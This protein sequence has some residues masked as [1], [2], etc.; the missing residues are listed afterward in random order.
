MRFLPTLFASAC[1][2]LAA[3][4]ADPPAVKPAYTSMAYVPPPGL[5]FEVTGIARLPDGRV[6]VA[7]RKGEVWL[8]QHPDADPA[9]P[10]AV[11]Y[12][13]IASGLHEALGLLWHNG[14][15]LTMQRSE[16]TRLR[17]LDGD[18]IIDD[19]EC[20]AKGWGVSGNYHEYAYGPVVDHEGNLWF[21]LNATLGGG[22]RMP[23]HRPADNPWRGWAMRLTPAGALER[24]APASA[25]RR[26]SG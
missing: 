10:E 17:D 2:S 6:A 21:S 23:G 20:A 5:K 22:V 13:R 16:L 11:G 25:R 3:F 18:D 24:C 15:L 4:A 26:A 9:D 14:A 8:L 1:A 7:L 12:R 19:Y